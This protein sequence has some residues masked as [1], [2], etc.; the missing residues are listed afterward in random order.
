MTCLKCTSMKGFIIS[1][2]RWN[3]I[4]GTK[5]LKF[6]EHPRKGDL[7]LQNCKNQMISTTL[8]SVKTTFTEQIQQRHYNCIATQCK[9]HKIELSHKK[10]ICNGEENWELQ[11]MVSDSYVITYTSIYTSMYTSILNMKGKMFVPI[12]S[13]YQFCFFYIGLTRPPFF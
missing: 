11:F 2:C 13:Y 1:K 4:K 9:F 3:S 7:I 10:L 5:W 6:G 12:T 8:T